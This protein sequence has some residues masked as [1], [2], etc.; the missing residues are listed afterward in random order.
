MDQDHIK[1]KLDLFNYKYQKYLSKYENL[2]KNIEG[3]AAQGQDQGKSKQKR[4]PAGATGETGTTGA[5]G[6]TGETGTTGA[7]G[8]TGVTGATG[9]TGVTGAT[10]ATGADV[11]PTGTTVGAPLE[12]TATATVV[13]TGTG[14][15]TTTVVPV[16]TGIETTTASIVP[17]NKCQFINIFKTEPKIFFENINKCSTKIDLKKQ[18]FPGS[19]TSENEI[20]AI[21]IFYNSITP[22]IFDNFDELKELLI[23]LNIYIS[24]NTKTDKII[25]IIQFLNLK[26]IPIKIPFKNFKQSISPV[27]SPVPSPIPDPKLPT[28]KLPLCGIKTPQTVKMPKY[29]QILSPHMPYQLIPL[30]IERQ[31]GGQME[32]LSESVSQGNFSDENFTNLMKATKDI[33]S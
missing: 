17:L 3:G 22:E 11:S 31:K 26:N 24:E 23:E 1:N 9:A 32:P 18:I 25:S 2:L 16:G 5:T 13:G 20:N 30:Q 21:D 33:V 29:K 4:N 8:A 12:T 19:F 28:L 14:T 27:P 6:A 10:G 7:T 15:E